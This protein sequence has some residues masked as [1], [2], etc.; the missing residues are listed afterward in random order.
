MERKKKVLCGMV[1][2][3]WNTPSPVHQLCVMCKVCMNRGWNMAPSIHQLCVFVYVCA[4]YLEPVCWSLALT[5]LC[6]FYSSP[7]RSTLDLPWTLGLSPGPGS[8]LVT[9]SKH[10]PWTH[11]GHWV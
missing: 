6:E 1:R 10:W 7:C 4:E 3:G 5:I 9:G 11:P 2:C 8:T